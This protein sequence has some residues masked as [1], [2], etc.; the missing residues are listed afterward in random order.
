MNMKAIPATKNASKI[1]NGGILPHRR[2]PVTIASVGTKRP[3]NTS[4][5]YSQLKPKPRH[6]PQFHITGTFDYP[7]ES[8]CG[9]VTY[10]I[11]DASPQLASS[12]YLSGITNK[13]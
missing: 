2:I 11:P 13:T 12:T 4:G 9:R 5:N 10:C 7:V 8:S 1:I 6:R 3:D